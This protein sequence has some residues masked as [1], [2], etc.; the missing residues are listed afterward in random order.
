M[1]KRFDCPLKLGKYKAKVK[2]EVE[3]KMRGWK[4]LLSGMVITFPPPVSDIANDGKWSKSEI[5]NTGV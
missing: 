5:N 3:V 2:V 1:H 4:L